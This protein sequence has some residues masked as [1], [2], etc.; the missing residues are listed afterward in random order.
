VLLLE[1]ERKFHQNFFCP[2]C[3]C[4]NLCMPKASESWWWSLWWWLSA[5]VLLLPKNL[6]DSLYTILPKGSRWWFKTEP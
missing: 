1:R 2:V 4:Y 5:C 3:W 6:C